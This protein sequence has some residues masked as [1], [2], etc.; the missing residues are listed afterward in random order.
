MSAPSGANHGELPIIRSAMPEL[1]V[2]RGLA[3]LMVFVLH[4]F[5]D[6]EERGLPPAGRFF[7]LATHYGW[8][9]VNHFFVLPDS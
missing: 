8:T 6:R 5:F 9:G 7:S 3:I 2:I 4:S 1:D